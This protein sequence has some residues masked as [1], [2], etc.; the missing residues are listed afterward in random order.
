MDEKEL[1]KEVPDSTACTKDGTEKIGK[2]KTL[3]LAVVLLLLM[4]SPL[5]LSFLVFSSTSRSNLLVEFDGY[6][7]YAGPIPTNPYSVLD[8]QLQPNTEDGD[9]EGE[10][11]GEGVVVEDPSE[12]EDPSSQGGTVGTGT[13]STGTGSTGT[14]SSGSGSSSTGSGGSGTGS[15]GSGGTGTGGTGPTKVWHEGWTEVIHHPAEYEEVWHPEE[16]H[17]GSLCNT[18]GAEISG[19]AA[20]HLLDSGHSSYRTDVYFIDSP[21]WIENVLVK[22]AWDETIEH[23]GYWE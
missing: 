3:F 13:G 6:T 11:P 12:T 16:G 2:G 14:G 1:Q 21:A 10:E 7:G 19:F 18:C 8:Q 15:G 9:K 4:L 5:L 20:Q 17:Y 23:P 22:A